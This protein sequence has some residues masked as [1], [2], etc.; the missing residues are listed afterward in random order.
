[1]EEEES[2]IDEYPPSDST[3]YDE[4]EVIRAMITV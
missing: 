3:L 4:D 2:E 1:V